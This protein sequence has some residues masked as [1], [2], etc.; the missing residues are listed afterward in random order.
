MR[1]HGKGQ[2]PP[3]RQSERKCLR[4][5]SARFGQHIIWRFRESR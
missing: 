2:E 5:S 1:S 3:G 4:F